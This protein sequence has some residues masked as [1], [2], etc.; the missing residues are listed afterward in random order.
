MKGMTR[1][2]SSAP[3]L[4]LNERWLFCYNDLSLVT[5]LLPVKTPLSSSR[6]KVTAVRERSNPLVIS[7]SLAC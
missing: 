2:K 7:G 1:V 5:L 6:L 4:V 3:C